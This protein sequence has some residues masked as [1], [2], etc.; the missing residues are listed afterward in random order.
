MK[1]GVGMVKSG[2]QPELR[3][4]RGSPPNIQNLHLTQTI[5][6]KINVIMTLRGGGGGGGGS[7]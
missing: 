5:F 1:S 4:G 2:V 3:K 7:L 6:G